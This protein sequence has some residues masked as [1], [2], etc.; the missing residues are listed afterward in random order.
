MEGTA[1]TKLEIND[2]SRPSANLDWSP[3]FLALE[4][5]A[6]L[7]T[8]IIDVEGWTEESLC[9]CSMGSE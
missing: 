9:K 2:C 4:K 8:L 6:W 1:V 5:N 3:I 7:K